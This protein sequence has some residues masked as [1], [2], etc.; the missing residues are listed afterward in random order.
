MKH[1]HEFK[2]DFLRRSAIIYE[3][4]KQHESF[5]ETRSF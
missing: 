2:A 3:A 5:T 1:I 4:L